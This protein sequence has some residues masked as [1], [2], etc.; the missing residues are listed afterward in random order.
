MVCKTW[1]DGRGETS[2]VP[3]KNEDLF[4]ALFGQYDVESGNDVADNWIS[5]DLKSETDELA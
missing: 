1:I 2:G 4:E 5:D 3:K